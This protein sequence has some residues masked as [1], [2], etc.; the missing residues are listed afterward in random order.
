MAENAKNAIL[1][2][3]RAAVAAAP[4][5]APIPRDYAQ[6]DTRDRGAILADLVDRLE[7]YKARVTR[8]TLA[9]LPDAVARVCGE[10]AITT[11]VTPSDLPDLWLPTTIT[12]LRDDPPLSLAQL[13]GSEGVITGCEV[14]IAQTGTIILTCGV[15]QGRR[16][17]SLVPDRHLCVVRASQVVGIL[18]EGIAQIMDQ[19]TRPMTLIAGPSAT[20]DIEL[21]RVEGVHGPRTLYV[22][23]VEDD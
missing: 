7:D 3:I 16:L 17:I 8:T 13:D 12:L 4:A 2:R 10:L 6:R 11:L 9:R 19:P 22:L 23:L 21:S 20:S 5:T 1:R 18:P 14:A 15:G